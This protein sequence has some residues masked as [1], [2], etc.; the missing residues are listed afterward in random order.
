[1]SLT[2]AEIR[3]VAI[4]GHNGTGK[5]TLL[6]HILS[7]SGVISRAESIDTGKTVSDYTD[8][9]IEKGISIHASL[10]SIEWDNK[11][12]NFIDTPGTADFVGEVVSSFRASESAIMVI[13]ARSG[14]QIETIKLWRRLNTRNMPRIVF[15]NKMDRDRA[16]FQNTFSD[17]ESRFSKPCVP[18]S[19][20]IGSGESYQ[21][22]INLIEN[23]AYLVSKA[24]ASEIPD[25]MKDTVEEFR[26]TLIEA[27]AE[28]EDS[29]MEKYFDEGTLNPDDIRLGLVSGLR[30]N[31]IIPILCGSAEK[32]NGIVSLLNFLS[33]AAPP[34]SMIAEKA[35]GSDGTEFPVPVSTAG[36]VS[37][38][39]FKTTIDQFSGKLSFIK[40]VTGIITAD[41][42]LQNPT[43]GK[44]E[45][46]GKLYKSIGKKLFEVKELIAGDIGIIAK[47]ANLH[48]NNTLCASDIQYT[49][50]VLSLPHPIHALTIS[51]ADKKSEDKM[52]EALHKVTEED[53]TFQINFNKETKENVV[54]GM[55]ELHINMI[56]ERIKEKQKIQINTKTPKIAYRETITKT[57]EAEYT[58]KKQSGGHG[59]YGRVV[60]SINP[61]PRGEY[62][63]FNNAIKGGS[64]SKGYMP[65]IEKG[66][67]EAMTEG[68]LAGYPLVDIGVSVVDGKEHPVDSSEMAFKLAAKGALKTA[69]VKANVVLL[70]PIMKLEVYIED[71]YL[72][73]ILSDLSGKRGRVQGQ[74][75]IGGGLTLVQAKVPQGE[76]LK[77]AIDLK[78]LTSGTGSFELEFDHYEIATGKVVEDVIKQSQLENE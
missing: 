45:R 46:P 61:L 52:N 77:Y 23:K 62:F 13:D 28:G 49:F 6:E 5:T 34:P 54:S 50:A 36:S 15:I 51:A 16:D 64:I 27:A 73:D 65:G 59:Q 41:A 4:V 31:R 72:G 1:M 57:S 2:S 53:L 9:E 18:V 43:I 68:F 48:T 60:I 29:L 75:D 66:L 67:N 3:N 11:M 70:E 78:S 69:M 33:F 63:S 56:L 39:S 12:M 38:F 76:M 42:E 8:E 20:P 71:Q 24:T 14:V 40:V 10:S 26:L 22:V 74:E 58:H 32:D 35:V 7:N 25:D 21:G 19:I 55:G 37:A 17:I 47:S 30:E 44:K